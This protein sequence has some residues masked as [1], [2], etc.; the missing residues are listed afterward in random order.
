MSANDTVQI[1][2]AME[3]MRARFIDGLPQRQQAMHRLC[4]EAADEVANG[5]THGDNRCRLA[6]L[7]PSTASTA[8]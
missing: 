5:R 8:P 4:D 1:Q 7:L 2:P 3:A 6:V